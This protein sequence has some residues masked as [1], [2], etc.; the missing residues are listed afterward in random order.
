MAA[1]HVG[2]VLCQLLNECVVQQQHFVRSPAAPVRA[3]LLGVSAITFIGLIKL[4]L[5]GAGVTQTV[6]GLWHKPDRK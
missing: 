1:M 6:K 5:A 2:A 4:N 3:G